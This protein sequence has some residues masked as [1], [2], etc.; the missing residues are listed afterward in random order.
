[1]TTMVRMTRRRGKDQEEGPRLRPPVIWAIMEPP[2]YLKELFFASCW[3]LY[4][5]HECIPRVEDEAEADSAAMRTWL[6][7]FLLA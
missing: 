4:W 6:M 2:R 3:E 5:L 7:P 1:M